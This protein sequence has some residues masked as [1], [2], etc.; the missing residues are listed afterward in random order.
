MVGDDV[1]FEPFLPQWEVIK[2][3]KAWANMIQFVFHFEKVSPVVLYSTNKYYYFCFFFWLD[4]Q[5]RYKKAGT[6][7]DGVGG[8]G[9]HDP[10][11]KLWP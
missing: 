4:D 9:S 1:R 5:M 2:R 11:V 8:V 7:K 6:L 3:F 10:C